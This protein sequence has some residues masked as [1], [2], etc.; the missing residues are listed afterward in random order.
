MGA[1]FLTDPKDLDVVAKNL[2]ERGWE[3]SVTEL[4]Y[5]AKTPAEPA[6]EER[7]EVVSFL[8]ALDEHD[9]VHRVY[10]ALK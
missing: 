6:P 5:E 4:S 10:A 2:A 1:R 7:T 8:Q 9:D 3:L